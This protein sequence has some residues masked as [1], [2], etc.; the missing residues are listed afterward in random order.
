MPK[1]A[2]QNSKVSL[3][4]TIDNIGYAAPF[5]PRPCLLV[6]REMKTGVEYRFLLKADVRYW[7][8]G[9]H[10]VKERIVIGKLPFGKYETFLAL[11]DADERLQTRPEYG[12]QLADKNVWEAKTGYNKLHHIIT[13]D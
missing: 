8:S 2:K 6:L 10:T 4:L 3:S 12:I 5:N 11:P 1:K 7:F 9:R 13:I